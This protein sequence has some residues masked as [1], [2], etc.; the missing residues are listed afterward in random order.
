MATSGSSEKA[1]LTGSLNL[2]IAQREALEIEAD[3]IGSELKSPGPNGEPPAGIKDSLIDSE[4]YPRGDIDIY[5]V[6]SKRKRLAEINVDYKL[7]MKQIEST[8]LTLYQSFP[9][10]NRN[11]K[12]DPKDISETV[13]GKQHASNKEADADMPVDSLRPIAKLDQILETSPA[14]T[15]G[16]QDG[17][18]LLQFGSVTANT[19][20]CLKSITKLVGES[21]NKSIL[22]VVRR[23]VATTDSSELGAKTIVNLSITPAAWGGRG[24]LGC[25]LTPVV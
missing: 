10:D 11:E 13:G 20:D 18:E 1:R 2:L 9:A 14:F 7:L 22:L 4:G 8:M 6:K 15:A 16:I 5:N 24:L 25:H 12:F 19:P 3:A 23:K 17:D 21:L